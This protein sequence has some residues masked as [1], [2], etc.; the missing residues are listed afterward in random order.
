MNQP[1]L[2]FFAQGG[3]G[4][5]STS[6]TIIKKSVVIGEDGEKKTRT[7]KRV[8]RDG[9]VVV[10]STAQFRVNRMLI[11]DKD[12]EL[13]TD[14]PGVYEFGVGNGQL[15]MKKIQDE[16]G[17]RAAIL[18]SGPWKEKKSAPK[19]PGTKEVSRSRSRGTSARRSPSN[20]TI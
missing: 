4:S 20:K 8:V 18:T 19:K 13:S 17:G 15:V 12:G 11:Q 14:K 10:N 6:T 7:Y 16:A 9:K 2:D 1:V 5:K 3:D